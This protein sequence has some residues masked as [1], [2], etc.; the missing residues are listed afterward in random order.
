VQKTPQKAVKNVQFMHYLHRH[1]PNNAFHMAT[2]IISGEK[3][4][5]NVLEK[6]CINHQSVSIKKYDEKKN[7][8]TV[9]AR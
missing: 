9:N 2:S 6:N 5:F 7:Q 3:G 8:D 1:D 4:S